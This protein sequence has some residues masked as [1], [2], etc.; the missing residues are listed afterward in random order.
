MRV[1]A[2]HVEISN[3]M[4]LDAAEPRPGP[5]ASNQTY[6]S[7]I[8][9]VVAI[10]CL[11]LVP[12]AISITLAI[13]RYR[14]RAK[15][16]LRQPL[17][18]DDRE[19]DVRGRQNSDVNPPNLSSYPSP[20]ATYS[21]NSLRPHITFPQ[22]LGQPAVEVFYF[23]VG[24]LTGPQ[25]TRRP[26]PAPVMEPSA[27]PPG[28]PSIPP[29]QLPPS[30][31]HS[32]HGVS[33]VLPEYSERPE[34]LYPLERQGNLFSPL[35]NQQTI[36]ASPSVNGHGFQSV[37]GNNAA[38]AGPSIDASPPVVHSDQGSLTPSASERCDSGY[39]ETAS[40]GSEHSDTDSLSSS[41]RYF[42]SVSPSLRSSI[43]MTNAASDALELANQRAIRAVSWAEDL[44]FSTSSDDWEVEQSA[45]QEF[46]G[47]DELEFGDEH[48]ASISQ[49]GDDDDDDNDL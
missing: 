23:Q 45:D 36:A 30:A 35:S 14:R 13:L 1:R 27:R 20:P 33:S 7:R 21:P 4:V 15:R 22:P 46:I 42:L 25:H 38:T 11:V 44:E 6:N 37:D 48:F 26:P 19:V 17:R 5:A 9:H 3:D 32:L 40:Y 49:C 10:G 16:R 29:L 24:P 31:T 18:Y 2:P 43:M 12:V 28:T 34:W 41:I 39:Q 8:D 47:L